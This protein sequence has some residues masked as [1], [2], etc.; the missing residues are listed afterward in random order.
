LCVVG[1]CGHADR[2]FLGLAVGTASF[3]APL[4][5]SEM[6]PP[7]VR[8]GL[9]SFNQL[10]VTTGILVAPTWGAALVIGMLSVPQTPH[11]LVSV[12]QREKAR[13]YSPNCAPGTGMDMHIRPTR[14]EDC[15]L[16]A[17]VPGSIPTIPAMCGRCPAAD[18]AR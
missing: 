12:G 14:P 9:V 13:L 3:V 11:W 8:G 17:R 4:Y 2:F 7:R 10:A 18:G 5:I 16:S 6:A 1:Q 15:S